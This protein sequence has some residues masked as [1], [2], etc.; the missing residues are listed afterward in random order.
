MTRYQQLEFDWQSASL[1]ATSAP[2]PEPELADLILPPATVDLREL[3][4]QHADALIE[5]AVSPAEGVINHLPWDFDR[6]FPAPLDEAIAAGTLG[7]DELGPDDIASIHH[8][9][10]NEYL[11]VLRELDVA[12][13]AQ[14]SGV[15]PR[16]G[17]LP[18]TA[19]SRDRL[20]RYLDERVPRL[21]HALDELLA[22]Y[23]TAFGDV[24][25]TAFRD[26]LHARH[27][28]EDARLGEMDKAKISSGAVIAF[29]LASAEQSSESRS[30]S[31]PHPEMPCPHP[32]PA[33]IRRAAFGTD[34][35]GEPVE[36]SEEEVA[37][38]TVHHGERLMDALESLAA[39][40]AA[41]ARGREEDRDS[42][43]VAVDRAR[44]ACQSVLALY[45]EDFGERAARELEAWARHQVEQSSEAT[46]FG[47]GHPWYY[48][49]RGD[50]R[51]PVPV[52]EIPMNARADIGLSG[53]LP[54]DHE[55]RRA[56][57]LKALHEQRKQ[58]NEDRERYTQL[59]NHGSDALSVYDCEIAHAGDDELAWASAVALKYNHIA[60]CL[61]RIAKLATAL[62]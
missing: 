18:R 2:A 8:E 19:K 46:E 60:N 27:D 9:H 11:A 7:T 15:D 47:P 55:K 45:E 32:L 12:T 44:S 14:Q 22:V 41:L 61:G 42:G 4:P 38:I 1:F 24:A 40:E 33:A 10:G 25:A 6:T 23:G 62:E 53:R 37:E 52:D 57:L 20:R 17:K 56:T 58:L 13:A 48:L 49:R 35:E 36:P 39:A 54:R 34:E 29:P 26:H 51:E 50:G 5:G 31:L 16:T 21:R 43:V 59:V 30:D 3:P 28:G